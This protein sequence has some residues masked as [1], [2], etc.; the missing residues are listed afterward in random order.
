MTGT[1]S[2]KLAKFL[3]DSWE[4]NSKQDYTILNRTSR[5]ESLLN[6]KKCAI[7]GTDEVVTTLFGLAIGCSVTEYSTVTFCSIIL[8]SDVFVPVRLESRI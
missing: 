6:R 1:I 8:S 4:E 2:K 3:L 5:T 7:V